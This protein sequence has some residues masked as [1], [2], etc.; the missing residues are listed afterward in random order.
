M[1]MWLMINIH[2]QTMLQTRG[3]CEIQ[4]PSARA[5]YAAGKKVKI[6]EFKSIKKAK[7]HTA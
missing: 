2:S 1:T 3:S 5:A 6:N 7:E 4:R